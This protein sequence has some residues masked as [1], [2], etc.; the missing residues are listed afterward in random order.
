MLNPDREIECRHMLGLC[1]LEQ[2]D[3]G[4]A[5]LEFE[6]II[7]FEDASQEQ[8]ISARFELGRAFAGLGE[9]ERA[10]ESFEAVARIDPG[11]C[12]VAKHLEALDAP[13]A[14]A[15]PS[16]ESFDDLIA[17]VESGVEDSAEDSGSD[18]ESFD[19]VMDEDAAEA[20]EAV[21]DVDED[22]EPP[23]APSPRKRK[24]ISFV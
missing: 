22:D 20:V 15:S 12:D 17:D 7:A 13:E 18:Y 16:L 4:D 1:C 8:Q 5:V 23:A 3:P 2:E 11:F 21:G 9:T 19:D 10:R 6:R 14:D 24:K